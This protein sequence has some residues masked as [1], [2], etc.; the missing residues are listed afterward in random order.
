LGWAEGFFGR[1]C[2]GGEVQI[3]LEAELAG[4]Q[5]GPVQE[6]GGQ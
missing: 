5:L 2:G 3:V 6:A 4:G 1:G